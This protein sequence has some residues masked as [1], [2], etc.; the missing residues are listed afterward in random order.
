MS[1]AKEQP[2]FRPRVFGYFARPG[3]ARRAHVLFLQA[4]LVPRRPPR[5]RGCR[6]T[7]GARTGE[8][9]EVGQGL[10]E[11]AAALLLHGQRDDQEAVGQL[12]EVLDEV[13]LPAETKT[14]L[15][16]TDAG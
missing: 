9:L 10:G 15:Q 6:C 13:V 7:R 3:Q 5:C 14:Q 8:E 12:R 2:A 16:S 1:P 11:D 4:G